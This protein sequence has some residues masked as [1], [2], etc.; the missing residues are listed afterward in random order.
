MPAG[1]CVNRRQRTHNNGGDDV[2]LAAILMYFCN[3][4]LFA[5]GATF[6]RGPNVEFFNSTFSGRTRSVTSF[7]RFTPDHPITKKNPLSKC[8]LIVSI[9]QQFTAISNI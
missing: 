1:V 7:S 4:V 8:Y 3:S 2:F 5:V 9:E 6:G